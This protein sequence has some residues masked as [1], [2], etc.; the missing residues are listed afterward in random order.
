MEEIDGTK[1][2][3]FKEAH[4]FPEVIEAS[5]G[6]GSDGVPDLEVPFAVMECTYESV[7]PQEDRHDDGT[8][9]D[10]PSQQMFLDGQSVGFFDS[11][12]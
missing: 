5:D 6:E 4:G 11:W 10:F 1:P 7:N 8:V 12:E 3:D 9:A 2:E